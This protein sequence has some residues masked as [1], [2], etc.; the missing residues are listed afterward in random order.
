VRVLIKEAL[1]KLIEKQDLSEQEVEACALEIAKGEATP[2]QVGAF[3][4]A[5][6]L[7]GEGEKEVA[8]FARVMRSLCIRVDLGDP[9]KLVDTAGTGGDSLKTFNVSTASALV[10]AAS[11]VRV[12]KHGNR[13]VSGKSGSA[14]LLEAFGV[15]IELDQA[16]VKRCFENAGIAFL[17]APLFHPAMRNVANIRREL[18]FRT[19]FNL[20]GPLTNPAGAKRQLLGV[21]TLPALSLVSK[22]LSTL[23]TKKAYVVH[24]LDGLDEVSVSA[25]TV[26]NI[27]E[28]DSL[29]EK[30]VT[31][32]LLGLKRF[33]NRLL[34]CSSVEESAKKVYGVLS[35]RLKRDSA[36]VAFVAANAG[37]GFVVADRAK[38]EK[39]GV[40]IALETIASGK[41]VET[42]RRLI[43]AS[44]GSTQ[45][46]EELE[47]VA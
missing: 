3:L 8:A 24:G 34:A 42:L 10:L 35:G 15:K 26:V 43:V 17:F 19:V 31:P 33:E 12:A 44:G 25:P 37:V 36:S 27:V 6:K 23:D 4:T 22:A 39:E 5:L 2:A 47:K 21:A 41:A 40:E 11:G 32:E 30:V 38:D 7:K 20:L 18:G 28:D 29:S 14:D 1:S 45:K 16:G 9:E 13:A 46:L